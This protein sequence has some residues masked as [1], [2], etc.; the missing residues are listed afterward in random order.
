MVDSGAKVR[1]KYILHGEAGMVEHCLVRVER[2]AIRVQDDNGLRYSI[3]NPAK[4]PLL[5]KEFLL[6]PFSIFDVSVASKPPDDVAFSVELW[7]D[8]YEEPTVLSVISR[9]RVSSSP[10]LGASSKACHSRTSRSKSSG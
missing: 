10:G 3:G 9:M 7:N 4:L 5:L 2:L 1:D 6:R 8:T